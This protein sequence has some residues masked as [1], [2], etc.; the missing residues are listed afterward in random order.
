MG[1]IPPS[2]SY[3]PL[4]ASHQTGLSG[5]PSTANAPVNVGSAITV[6]RNGIMVISIKA[7]VSAETGFIDY[8]ITRGGTTYYFPGGSSSAIAENTNYG[9][10]ASNPTGHGI[11]SI[12]NQEALPSFFISSGDTTPSA[13][14]INTISVLANDTIQFRVSNSTANDTTYIDD[15]TVMLI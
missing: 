12:T 3:A 2:S 13:E 6:S 9:L 5:T 11:T 4:L 7:H 8:T 14:G 10:F 15:L 1:Y